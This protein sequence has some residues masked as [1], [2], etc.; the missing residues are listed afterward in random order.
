MTG[1]MPRRYSAHITAVLLVAV[2]VLLSPSTAHADPHAIFY[3]ATGQR[4]LFFNV[5]A[6]L[7]QA[8]YV[9]PEFGEFG[10]NELLEKRDAQ[11]EAELTRPPGATPAPGAK[12]PIIEATKTDLS[13]LLTRAITLEGTALWTEYVF[14]QNALDVVR[15]A[16]SQDFIDNV[17]CKTSLGR[18]ECSDKP[19]E[20]KKRE[21]AYV[22]DPAKFE[23]HPFSYGWV[24]ALLTGTDEHTDEARRLKRDGGTKE[25]VPGFAANPSILALQDRIN[26]RGRSDG[27]TARG[28]TAAAA[29][30]TSSQGVKDAVERGITRAALSEFPLAVSEDLY[31]GVTIDDE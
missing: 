28:P 17:L 15:T 23:S 18:P 10:R 24:A 5:L 11:I 16:A 6:A 21:I 12:D 29:A 31:D 9:E 14:R 27:S 13:G 8:D 3:T 7:D 2:G 25:F 22:T 4:Q 30:G 1:R 19:E 20:V 26:G